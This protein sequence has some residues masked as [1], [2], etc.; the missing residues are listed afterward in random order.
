M[1]DLKINTSGQF[2][3]TPVDNNEYLKTTGIFESVKGE[4][5]PY[6]EPEKEKMG[7][8][9]KNE[10]NAKNISARMGYNPQNIDV[11]QNTAFTKESIDDTVNIVK[12]TGD[13]LNKN[14]GKPS[15]NTYTNQNRYNGATVEQANNELLGEKIFLDSTIATV[16]E[17]LI[18]I[19]KGFSDHEMTP[20]ELESYQVMLTN[21]HMLRAKIAESSVAYG[22]KAIIP[23]IAG[24]LVGGVINPVDLIINYGIGFATAGAGLIPKILINTAGNLVSSQIQ[25]KAVEN[26]NATSEELLTAGIMGIAGDLVGEYSTRNVNLSD[27]LLGNGAGSPEINPTIKHAIES[28]HDS[29]A[30][31]GATRVALQTEFGITDGV[32]AVSIRPGDIDPRFINQEYP[33]WLQRKTATHAEQYN[34]RNA[35]INNMKVE[36]EAYKNDITIA[37]E[38]I[39][40]LNNRLINTTDSD[41]YVKTTIELTNATKE[42]EKLESNLIAYGENI[43]KAIESLGNENYAQSMRPINFINEAFEGSKNEFRAYVNGMNAEHK[44]TKVALDQ[45]KGYLKSR[46]TD[47]VNQSALISNERAGLLGMRPQEYLNAQSDNKHVAKLILSD[48]LQHTT[49]TPNELRFFNAIVEDSKILLSGADNNVRLD[50]IVDVDNFLLKNKAFV[51]SNGKITESAKIEW[52]QNNPDKTIDDFW[53]AIYDSEDFNTIAKL[54]GKNP[55]IAL[56][57]RETLEKPIPLNQIPQSYHD[58]PYNKISKMEVVFNKEAMLADIIP[59]FETNVKTVYKKRPTAKL[60]PEGERIFDE[61][62][63]GL[64]NDE[65]FSKATVGFIGNE[66]G[67]FMIPVTGRQERINA[68]FNF[69]NDLQNSVSANLGRDSYVPFKELSSYFKDVDAMERFLTSQDMKYISDNMSLLKYSFE[70]QPNMISK[71]HNYGT[72]SSS[73][74]A[75]SVNNAFKNERNTG[76]IFGKSYSNKDVTALNAYEAI[77]NNFMK[78]TFTPEMRKPLEGFAARADWFADEVL[79][80]NVMFGSGLGENFINPATAAARGY[81][82]GA[83][84]HDLM[85]VSTLRKMVKDSAVAKGINIAESDYIIAQ[86]I[87]NNEIRHTGE[88]F[89]TLGLNEKRKLINKYG[90]EWQ[91]QSEVFLNKCADGYAVSLIHNLDEDFGNLR[92][93]MKE[94]LRRRG[95]TN[96][97]EYGVF[98]R[99]SI[100]H[101]DENGLYVN[102]RTLLDAS[103]NVNANALRGVYNDL[104]SQ[105]GDI[106]GNSIFRTEGRAVID[107]YLGMF[108][109]FNRNMSADFWH[110]MAYYTN[111]DGLSLARFSK[112]L[113]GLKSFKKD[114]RPVALME[115]V[116]MYYVGGKGYQMTKDLAYGDRD[117]S[118]RMGLAM[119]RISVP[120]YNYTVHGRWKAP[121]AIEVLN[122]MGISVLGYKNGKIN[123]SLDNLSSQ[124]PVVSTA[125][126]LWKLADKLY[127][128]DVESMKYNGIDEN[129]IEIAKVLTREIGWKRVY[130]GINAIGKTVGG[131]Y[132]PIKD[133]YDYDKEGNMIYKMEVN[134]FRN[135]IGSLSNPITEDEIKYAENKVNRYFSAV[136][137][138]A[139]YLEDSTRSWDNLDSKTKFLGNT[140][141]EMNGITDTRE[142]TKEFAVIA[143]NAYANNIEKSEIKK[144]ISSQIES[145]Y[146]VTI[147]DVKEYTDREIQSF[148]NM[149]KKQHDYYNKLMNFTG[150]SDTAQSRMKFN[151]VFKNATPKQIGNLLEK[152]Y[153][154][155]K[156]KFYDSIRNQSTESKNIEQSNIEGESMNIVDELLNNFITQEG[157][158]DTATNVKTGALGMTADKKAE[159]SKKYSK[160]FTDE[161][162]ARVFLT[163]IDNKVVGMNPNL[164]N[165]QRK[166]IVS[167][168]YN[169]GIGALG[170]SSFKEYVANPSEENLQKA[171]FNTATIGGLSSKGLANRR[172][173]DY[174]KSN[175]SELIKEVK[176]Y[177][178]G[179]VDYIGT[180]GNVIYRYKAK[181]IH[182]SSKPGSISINGVKSEIKASKKESNIT[183]TDEEG[184][185]IDATAGGTEAYRMDKDVREASN[186]LP[187]KKRVKYNDVKELVDRITST[188]A[189]FVQDDSLAI[190]G[191]DA[192]FNPNTKEIAIDLNKWDIDK[193]SYLA[194]HEIQHLNQLQD[195]REPIGALSLLNK[196]SGHLEYLTRLE[197]MDA[198]FAGFQDDPAA[199]KAF[200]YEY[201]DK[202]GL[203]KDYPID[204]MAKLVKE[205]REIR[206]KSDSL[207]DAHD[208]MKKLIKKYK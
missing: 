63:E 93:E 183:W 4:Y 2:E 78:N 19:Y 124:S 92:N 69:V 64:F 127:F 186:I 195:G 25:T 71:L 96:A 45:Y 120:Y 113:S 43:D 36:F 131:N 189:T 165:E 39:S 32:D 188:G 161:E 162:A 11:E 180:S 122:N 84:G 118:E 196:D 57:Y 173:E 190:G 56:Y 171:L 203:V 125:N 157:Y 141:M 46:Y 153:G 86:M 5:T 136:Q 146:G 52:L 53:N 115:L 44:N 181:G 107:K 176:Q 27:L 179:D 105:I 14:Y 200:L 99:Y 40:E 169:L 33:T 110:G 1:E 174:N 87:Y 94:V 68:L 67:L 100:D 201:Q 60:T 112:D 17:G 191:T 150:E 49:A 58:D 80:P 38:G 101:I 143:A 54:N 177:P 192:W 205:Y 15:V 138:R 18:T 199:V 156:S 91:K 151:K 16:N 26:R 48:N 175:P 164:N 145:N 116:A 13:W 37:K 95:I 7:I 148:N 158:G 109:G 142:F 154:V 172:A 114:F 167:T 83:S 70:E 89:F 79:T 185:P 31:K 208:K 132:G 55:D 21:Q 85:E 135:I 163:E 90:Y 198:M 47:Y 207:A 187:P 123:L 111:E 197:E 34:I 108:R 103:N 168:V 140:I 133:I 77:S 59:M 202:G 75:H 128:D 159:L 3:E 193:L 147:D 76:N 29:G 134:N 66:S 74:I 8:F 126:A 12:S 130:D 184:N 73:R 204:V 178:S 41:A 88:N 97:E 42:L 206:S 50:D 9:R 182:G 144:E 152:Y 51:D 194:E 24:G 10:D 20:E 139:D 155:D 30:Y 170:W 121:M 166:T 28:V 119:S 117:I 35:E 23:Q 104:V 149:P 82:L 22:D 102:S 62:F 106:K 81:G 160:N 98:R 137:A 72:T 65:T 6:V 61:I 129:G